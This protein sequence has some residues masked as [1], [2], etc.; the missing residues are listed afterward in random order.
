MMGRKANPYRDRALQLMRAGLAT[1]NEIALAT[2]LSRKLVENWRQRAQI[3]T[4]DLRVARVRKLMIR[5]NGHV[6]D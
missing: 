6:S 2:S 3:W 4:V 5:G 1:P